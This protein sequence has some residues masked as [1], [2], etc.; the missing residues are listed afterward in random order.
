MPNVGFWPDNDDFTPITD[1][2]ELADL[3]ALIAECVEEDARDESRWA[4]DAN[5]QYHDARQEWM[6]DAVP[7][8]DRS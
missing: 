2:A 5:L 7:K 4:Y 8:Q 3:D 6:R 1:P